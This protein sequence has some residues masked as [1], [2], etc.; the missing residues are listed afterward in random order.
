MIR[1]HR[2]TAWPHCRVTETELRLYR[3][4]ATVADYAP[5]EA[6]T[7]PHYACVANGELIHHGDWQDRRVQYSDD[8]AFVHLPGDP[9]SIGVFLVEALVTAVVAYAVG[10]GINALFGEPD[11][12]NP[13]EGAT[14]STYSFDGI[15]NTASSGLPIPI[16]YGTHVVGGN[17]VSINLEGNNPYITGENFGNA[18][19]LVLAICEGEID[20]VLETRINGN[21]LSAYGARATIEHNLGANYQSPLGGG[22][23]FQLYSVGLEL[24]NNPNGDPND[25]TTWQGGPILDYQTNQSVDR[26]RFNVTHPRG[27]IYLNPT[28]GNSNPETTAFRVRYRLASAP[29]GT[30]SPWQNRF[31]TGNQIA[32]FTTVEELQLPFRDVYDVQIQNWKAS[33]TS[34]AY[35]HDLFL[36][37]ITEVIDSDAQY[38]NVAHTRLRIEADRSASGALPTITQTIRGRKVQKWDGIDADNPTFVDASPYNNP[39]WCALDLLLNARY[40]MGRWFDYTNVDLQSFKDWADYCDEQVDDGTGNLEARCTFDA[41][42]DGDGN[43]WNTLLQ[44]AATSRAMFVIVGDTIRVKVEKARQPV[45]LFTMANIKR[46]SWRQA[47]VSNKLRSTRT[48][49]RYLNKDMDYLVDVEGVDDQDALELGLPQR[50]TTI[51]RFGITRRSQAVREARF[52]MNLQKLTQTVEF[53]ADLDAVLCEAGDL[54]RVAHDLPQWGYSG[55]IPTGAKFNVLVVFD[56]D[57]VLEEGETYEVCVRHPD[58]TIDIRTI[59]DPA[60]TYT[61]GTFLTVSTAFTYPVTAGSVYSMGKQLRSTR[62]VK[63]TDLRTSPNLTRYVAGVVYDERIHE[64]DVGLLDTITYTDLPSPYGVPGCV[65]QLVAIERPVVAGGGLDYGVEVSWT[66]P[67]DADIGG[68][69]IHLRDI[70]ADPVGKTPVIGNYQLVDEVAFPQQTI[71][72]SGM[73]ELG[74]T[75]EIAVM[76]E[77]TLG[78]SRTPGTC[79]IAEITITGAG[80][81]VPDAPPNFAYAYNGGDYLNLT[82]N[83]V[84]N[85]PVSHYEV[86][87]GAEWVGSLIV[88]VTSTTVLETQQWAPTH[89]STI[90]ERFFVRAISSAGVYGNTSVITTTAG[91]LIDWGSTTAQHSNQRSL[92]WPGTLTNLTNTSGILFFTDNTL[93]CVYE[94]PSIDTGAG[95]TYKIGAVW[96]TRNPAGLG[97]TSSLTF[98]TQPAR[99]NNWHDYVV[100]GDWRNAY[101]LEFRAS[102]DNSNWSDYTYLGV[103]TVSSAVIGGT[104]TTGLRYFQFRFSITPSEAAW[105]PQIEQLHLTLESR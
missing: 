101:A 53:E 32:P 103:P 75:Y 102:A 82:W 45:Q 98:N 34:S 81:I 93:P 74:H 105:A 35:H 51:D 69:T 85:I 97:W 29:T 33:P 52:A 46:D 1:V 3:D 18:L 94:T 25:T 40:G 36:D 20:A 78:A 60:G 84:N 76:A 58:D 68:A 4:D 57:V 23:Q 71:L 73:F 61:A 24:V 11:V 79:S 30:W 72:L 21:E 12:D 54:I 83:A 15:Q 56:R 31:V 59:T 28:N 70:T 99:D 14:S 6:L 38:P 27:L 88:G 65:S 104:P 9:V 87:R 8:L 92:S 91:S 96:H 67:T 95:G 86:R 66:Y 41:V 39:A 48:E 13:F 62:L 55:K 89:G 47:W 64:D 7:D 43:A 2:V 90:A 44:I 100:P 16:V 17:V 49:V 19:D 5:A 63:V 77:S 22:G 50:T 10:L 80:Q 42:I 26:V 37:S